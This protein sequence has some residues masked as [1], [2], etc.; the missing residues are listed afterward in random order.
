MSNCENCKFRA[1]YD[2]NPRSILGRIRQEPSFHL[3]QNLE[4]AY[5]LVSR[6]EGIFEITVRWGT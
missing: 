5:W 2:K 3:G 6:L 4:M 1:K